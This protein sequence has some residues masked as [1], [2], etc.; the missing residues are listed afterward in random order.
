MSTLTVLYF[1]RLREAVGIAE[2]TIT[3][4]PAVDTA[5]RLLA[6]LAEGDEQKRTAFDNQ[7]IRIAVNQV[8]ATP[9]TPVKP[10]D[11]VAFFPPVT[12]G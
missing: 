7:N 5:A 3:L 1:A 12:G 2:E 4:P 6:H 11:E 8:Q 9:Q 10:G